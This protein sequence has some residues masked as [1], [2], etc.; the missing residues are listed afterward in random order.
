MTV[1]TIWHF[2]PYL[3]GER[4][5]GEQGLTCVHCGEKLRVGM[6]NYAGT[7]KN[8]HNEFPREN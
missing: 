1:I 6:K 4:I 8:Q 7:S 5:G 2:C 3:M